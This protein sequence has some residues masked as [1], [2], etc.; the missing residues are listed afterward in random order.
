MYKETKADIIGCGEVVN[1]QTSAEMILAGAK[2]IQVGTALM[3]DPK[4]IVED[5]VKG[6]SEW[7]ETI[8]IKEISQA[9]GL[10]HKV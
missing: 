3:R 4:R 5:I 2:A 9:V 7:L 1:W 6:L 8:G 10:A